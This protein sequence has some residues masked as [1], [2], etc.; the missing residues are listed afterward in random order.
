MEGV[1]PS[2]CAVGPNK[3]I[4]ESYPAIPML[5]QKEERSADLNPQETS[6]WLEALEQV[7]D[8]E[9]PDRASYLLQKLAERAT[10][11]GVRAP[12]KPNTAVREHHRGRRASSL[13]RGPRRRA[14]HQKPDSLERHGHGGPREQV[15]RRTS[16]ATSRPMPRW[17]RCP[18]SGSTTSSAAVSATSRAT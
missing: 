18:K 5:K 14:A 12:L 1:E 3:V 2:D 10:H 8:E 15:R 7:I 4:V 16:A 6:E 9:G 11:S 17:R 13:P